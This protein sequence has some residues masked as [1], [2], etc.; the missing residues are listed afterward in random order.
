MTEILQFHPKDISSDLEK[1]A[2][3]VIEEG[4]IGIR[5]LPIKPL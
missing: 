5:Q 4:Q 2:F 1:G 3:I